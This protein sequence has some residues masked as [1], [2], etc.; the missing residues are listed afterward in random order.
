MT[1]INKSKKGKDS[2]IKRFHFHLASFLS[3][4]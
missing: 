2:G 1:L 4:L 3:K